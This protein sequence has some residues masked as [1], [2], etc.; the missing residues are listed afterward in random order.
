MTVSCKMDYMEMFGKN[1]HK[2][3]IGY[4][5]AIFDMISVCIIMYFITKLESISNEYIHLVDGN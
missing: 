3:V 2:E 1:I 5:V 4:I